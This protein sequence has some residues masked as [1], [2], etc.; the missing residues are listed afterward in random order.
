MLHVRPG[1]RLYDTVFANRPEPPAV[2]S[3]QEVL[4]GFA[5]TAVL[6][7]RHAGDRLENFSGAQQWPR[8]QLARGDGALARGLRDAHEALR[9]VLHIREIHE[10]GLPCHGDIG[11]QRQPHYRVHLK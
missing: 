9:R 4:V 11:A 5:L 1:A 6:R 10:R 3:A 8:L 7:G 2:E